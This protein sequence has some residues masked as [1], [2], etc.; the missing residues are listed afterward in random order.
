MLQEGISLPNKQNKPITPLQDDV[1]PTLKISYSQL[2]A[3][4]K[5][6]IIK[7]RVELINGDIIPMPPP[8]AP[9]AII[10]TELAEKLSQTLH[11]Y[12]KISVQNPLRLSH[13]LED[14]NLPLPDISVLKRKIYL[15]HPYPEDT[16]LVVEVA[17]SSLSYDRYRKRPLYA[18]HGIS[19]YWIV[20]LIDKYIEVYTN[21]Q[22]EDYL[23]R[24]SH[25][26]T[27]AFALTAFP[28]LVTQ[29]L[30]EEILKL[31]NSNK[32]V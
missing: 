10:I 13:D 14:K 20:N 26:F 17:D 6:G 22:G 16:Y 4:D 9:H 1:R 5:A 15:D 27:K 12:A 21:P 19:E 7:E 8:N 25:D 32:K 23:N 2:L 28:E 11:I 31:F 3:M 24:Q 29:W 30:P 18:R